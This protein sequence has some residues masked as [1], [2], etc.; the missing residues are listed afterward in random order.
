[1]GHQEW[2][3]RNVAK[4]TIRRLVWQRLIEQDAVMHDPI[5]RIPA[6]RSSHHAALTLEKHPIWHGTKTIKCNPD[7]AQSPVRLAALSA[8][9]TLL[10]AV[11]QL[12]NLACFVLLN[13][14][15]V[16]KAGLSFE[17]AAIA[18]NALEIGRP[19]LF[20]DIPPIDLVVVG[21]VAV[22]QYGGRTGKGAGFAD[23]ELGMM[24]HFGKISD[25]TP[26]VTTVDALQIVDSK[27][28]IETH[29]W[30]LDWIFTEK[31]AIATDTQYPKP[32]GM[33]WPDVKT[34]QWKTIPI[35]RHIRKG[36]LQSDLKIRPVKFS[37]SQQL[38]S[39]VNTV[40]AEKVYLASAKP[41]TLTDQRDHL[42]RI[43]KHRYPKLVAEYH[44]K[45]IGC[46]DIIPYPEIGFQHVGQ[47]GIWVLPSFREFG[48]G[49][50]LIK[51]TLIWAKK[52]GLEKVE[53]Q[54]FADNLQA[55][56][57]YQSIG[58]LVEGCRQQARKLDQK[59]QDL[60]LMGL[61]MNSWLPD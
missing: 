54:V 2:Q 6:Y 57:L 45:I 3:G 41:F 56:E 21:C 37:D 31:G 35:L 60:I 4:D 7:T 18:K 58:F 24:Q 27:L 36:E 22:D 52:Y 9:K 49:R 5:G 19:M 39:G 17:Q 15:L 25:R 8:G 38:L 50:S 55:I 47:L 53:L 61:F 13:Q 26:I 14:A 44:G 16:E 20:E 40:I 42:D 46:C 28:P 51:N 32:T 30:P 23:L 33:Y 59:Y 10:M 11:P 1:M 29:D 48:I 34:D 12:K 43:L